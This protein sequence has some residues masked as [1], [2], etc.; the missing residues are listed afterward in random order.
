[1]TEKTELVGFSKAELEAEIARIGEKPFRAKQVWHWLYHQGA[2]DFS[3]MS[4]L[5]KDLRQKLSENFTITRPKIVAEQVSADK[6]HKWLL[7]FSDGQRV[8][9]VY[10]PEE[11]RGTVCISTQVGC[12]VGC[13]F[14]HTGSQK[15]T[16]NLTAA[17]IVS[18]VMVARDAYNE[19][20]TATR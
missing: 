13:T 8:E 18:Q 17:E 7:E 10:I 20:P 1:M 4:N 15:I 5:S 19:W 9:T 2:V 11:D 12:A 3:Q 6:T 16:R 14:C